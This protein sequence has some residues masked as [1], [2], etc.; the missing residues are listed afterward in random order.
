MKK[1]K[2]I[3]YW[4]V[5]ASKTLHLNEV[6]GRCHYWRRATGTSHPTTIRRRVD[7][8]CDECQRQKRLL[9]KKK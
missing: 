6:M 2:V 4:R 7:R 5:R 8:V 1:P 9:R 3:D